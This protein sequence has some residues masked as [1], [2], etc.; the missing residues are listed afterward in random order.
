MI[1]PLKSISAFY[2]NTWHFMLYEGTL[3]I[4]PVRVL[5]QGEAIT[6]FQGFGIMFSLLLMALMF[7]IFSMCRRYPALEDIIMPIRKILYCVYILPLLVV[8]EIF[9]IKR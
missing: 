4:T 7:F 1:N 9:H 2:I 3:I 8:Q 6:R 5:I